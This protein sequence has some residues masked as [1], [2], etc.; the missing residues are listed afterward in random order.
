MYQ[1]ACARVFQ[2]CGFHGGA[3]GMLAD[4]AGGYAALTVAP[5]GMDITT[6]EYKVNF[7]AAFDHGE[8]RAVGTVV[9]AGKRFIVTTSN[10]THV[11]AT[12]GKES[13]CAISQQTLTP[14]PMPIR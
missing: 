13:M 5:A 10:I 11:D 2:F 8:L 3:I 1:H 12:T 9:R 7:L 6:V 4:V 14:V